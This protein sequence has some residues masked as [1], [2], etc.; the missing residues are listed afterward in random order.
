MSYGFEVYNAAGE[1]ILDHRALAYTVGGATTLSLDSAGLGYI[2]GSAVGDDELVVLELPVSRRLFVATD[3]AGDIA[4]RAVTFDDPG[5]TA[6]S[7][8]PYRLMRP[9]RDVALPDYGLALLNA[10]KEPTYHSGAPLLLVR[11][12][13]TRAVAHSD[14]S[15]STHTITSDVTHVAFSSAVKELVAIS[16]E[17]SRFGGLDLTRLS[18]TQIRLEN[19]LVWPGTPGASAGPWP[20]S[21]SW[22]TLRI[23]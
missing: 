17:L 13:G 23:T 21:V 15:T 9:F 18:S 22:L 12:G 20:T 2:A 14:Y 5:E 10:S 16:A 1:L 3:G 6:L 8:V 7:S 4:V 11:E 19:R